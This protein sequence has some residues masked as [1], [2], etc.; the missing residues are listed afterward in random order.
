MSTADESTRTTSGKTV[1][2]IVGSLRRAS[3][4]RAVAEQAARLLPAPYRA[5]FIDI[6][7]LG[8]FDQDH[9]AD[10][11]TPPSWLTF[12]D[13]VAASDALLFVTPEYNRSFPGVLKNALDIGSR[14]PGH[15]VWSGKPG[16]VITVSPGRIGGFGANNQLRQVLSFLNVLTLSSPESY[17]G[18]I[19]A[20][21]DKDGRVADEATLRHLTT[22]IEA[23]AAWIHRLG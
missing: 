12:R 8:P 1:G 7:D 17:F 6:R 10:N 11:T 16:A 20:Q 15:S 3:F 21:L 23:F 14:P 19:A 22:F 9:E 2:I 5:L 18:D 4:S 13:E